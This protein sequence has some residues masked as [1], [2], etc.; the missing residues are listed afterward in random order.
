MK[1]AIN[2]LDGATWPTSLINVFMLPASSSRLGDMKSV[3]H[4]TIEGIT[5]CLIFQF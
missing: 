4:L 3:I 2:Y 5:R 1:F